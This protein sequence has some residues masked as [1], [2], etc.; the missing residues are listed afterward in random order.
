MKKLLL[1]AV[2]IAAM[3]GVM[4]SS[5][6]KE[7]SAQM[8][9]GVAQTEQ[10]M[11]LEEQKVLDFLADYD[12]MKRGVKNEGEAVT[13]EQARWQW[14]TT[15]NYCHG[16]PL[17]Y[18]TNLH[19]DTVSIAMPKADLEGNIAYIDYLATYGKIVDAVRETYKAIDIEDK[20]L[21]FVM[22]SLD[23]DMA[24]DGDSVRVVLNTGS[25]TTDPIIPDPVPSDWYG[26]PFFEDECYIWG[27]GENSATDRLQLHVRNYDYNHSIAFEP[28]YFIVNPYRHSTYQGGIDDWLFYESGLTENEVNNY[29]LCWEYLNWEFGQIMEHTHTPYM[30]IRPYGHDGYFNIYVY[31]K[32]RC[33]NHYANPRLF[34]I[35]HVVEVD[36]ATIQPIINMNYPT[37]IDE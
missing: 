10:S 2:M 17:S 11:S 3:M 18:L 28:Y 20:T 16:Y 36:Y 8:K 15:L 21:Q 12:A 7:E 1:G 35:S 14:E 19:V 22:M 33:L 23:G 5:C 29:Y 30:E 27:G 4:M 26:I 24:K 31:G 32:K 13:P 9:D 6:K 34:E 37:P 25:R